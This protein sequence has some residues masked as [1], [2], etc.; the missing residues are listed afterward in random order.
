MVA[1]DMRAQVRTSVKDNHNTVLGFT[2]ADGRA[3]MC[4]IIIAA[5]RLKVTHVTGFN[6]LSKDAED[7]SSDDMKV[8]EDEIEQIKDEHSNGVDHMIPYGPTCSFNGSDVPIFFP[9]SNNG[10]NTRQLLTNMLSKMD[11]LDLFDRSDGVNPFL[12]C[13]GHGSRFAEPFL[14]YTLEV[15]RP[16]MCCIGV[17]YGTSMWQVG[18][19]TEQKGT[20]K[21]ESKKVKAA[22]LT[23]KIR[24]GL[25]PTLEQADIV[26]IVNVAWQHSFARVA[27]N[28]RAM[29]AL[30]W[31]PLNDILLDHPE[32]QETKDR[33]QSICEIYARQV[34]EGVDITDLISLNTDHGAMGLCMDMFLD[35][36]V[37][38][39]HHTQ[40]EKD[41][42]AKSRERAARLERIML[43]DKVDLVLG[44]GATPAADKWNNTDLKVMLQWFKRDGG[45][46]MPKKKEGLLLRYRETHTRVLDDTSTYPHE[47]V[48]AAVADAASSVA[49]AT[50]TPS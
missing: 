28:K 7:V 24:E 2:A 19:N 13:D 41:K 11:D 6:P 49:M 16:W 10:S 18:D 37:Q 22:S 44:K 4:S 36:K 35:H 40:L 12:L 14:E 5:S 27:T 20:F 21:I 50:V 43:K 45:K 38:E 48:G 15:S 3:I 8:L 29:S 25:F 30:G 1:K 23:S 31:V 26:R 34:R 17:Q 47:E 39:A 46:A 9:C 32:L 33:V 42:K